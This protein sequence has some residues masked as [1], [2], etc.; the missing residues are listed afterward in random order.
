MKKILL[1]VVLVAYG[2]VAGGCAQCVDCGKISHSMDVTKTVN[3]A[4][5]EERYN[6]YTYWR[7]GFAPMA[8][9]GLEKRYTIESSFWNPV[10]IERGELQDWVVEYRSTWRHFDDYYGINLD[11]K[12]YRVL[13]PSGKQVGIYYSTLEWTVFRFLENNVI[14][15]SIPQPSSRQLIRRRTFDERPL[16]SFF[17][18]TEDGAVVMVGPIVPLGWIALP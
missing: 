10:I 15:V 4:D 1:L 11:Y 14:R 12:G 6:Y 17:P 7:G 9:L 5:L 16:I 13:D 2:A 18:L 3:T 8:I